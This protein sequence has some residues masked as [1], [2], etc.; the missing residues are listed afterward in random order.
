MFVPRLSVRS[1]CSGFLRSPAITGFT[2]LVL[3][4]GLLLTACSSDSGKTSY[5]AMG[6]TVTLGSVSHTVLGADWSPGLGIGA[7]ARVPQNQ[8]LAIRIALANTADA[9]SDI[10]SMQ[11]IATDGTEFEELAD[12]SGLLDWLGLVRT[13]PAKESRQG[14]VLFDAPRGV[15]KLKLTEPSLDESDADVAF[16]EIPLR[17]DDNAIP[18]GADPT[19]NPIR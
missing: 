17:L 10:A 9:T 2:S 16:I 7:E 18:S 14:S 8:F 15:Y 13:L 11:L 5:A 19:A 1:L 4:L 3:A 6:E 12:G